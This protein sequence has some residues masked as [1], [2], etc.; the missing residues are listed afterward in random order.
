MLFLELFVS[1]G[2]GLEIPPRSHKIP[3]PPLNVHV[4]C[5]RRATYHK[6]HTSITPQEIKIH[7]S[8]S[9]DQKK[10]IKDET[11]NC[12]R[13]CAHTVGPSHPVCKEFC[14]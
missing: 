5:L 3:F 7:T 13:P 6:A 4:S 9:N 11:V 10:Q 2:P 14:R 12:S 1:K 8:P